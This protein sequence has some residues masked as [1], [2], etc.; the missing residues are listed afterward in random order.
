MSHFTKIDRANIIDVASFIEAC[1]ELGFTG[2][3]QNVEILDYY[4]NREIVEVAIRCGEYDIALKKN[5]TGT[6]DMIADWW[7]VR[8]SL[9]PDQLRNISMGKVVTDEDLQN[10]ILK[11]T[12]KR[13]IINKYKKQ[14]FRAT[15]HED[16]EQNLQVELVRY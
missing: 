4:K 7:G 16:E 14:G 5:S 2:I 11:H 13:T 1:N 6:Y 10:L 9:S 15:V 12:T 3:R 8:R